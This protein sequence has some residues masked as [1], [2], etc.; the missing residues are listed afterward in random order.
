MYRSEAEQ[1]TESYFELLCIISV[2][3]L[4]LMECPASHSALFND[5]IMKHLPLYSLMEKACDDFRNIKSAGENQE[6]S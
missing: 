5:V 2:V 1:F 3:L 6:I 4:N